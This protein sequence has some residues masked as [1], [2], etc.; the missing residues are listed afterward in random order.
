MILTFMNYLIILDTTFYAVSN[1]SS[2][3]YYHV[4]KFNAR[5]RDFM[6]KCLS[7]EA[8]GKNGEIAQYIRKI[9]TV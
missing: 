6:L 9:R 1:N 7:I 3:I 2:V 5:K 4:A 8:Y